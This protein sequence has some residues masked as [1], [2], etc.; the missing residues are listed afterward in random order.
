MVGSNIKANNKNAHQHPP[1]LAE[2]PRGRSTGWRLGVPRELRDGES[3]SSGA[4]TI[5]KGASDVGREMGDT[6][7]EAVAEGD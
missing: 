3:L 7:E 1:L 6:L 5:F 4:G 2:T